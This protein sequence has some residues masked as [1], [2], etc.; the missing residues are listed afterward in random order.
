MA[1]FYKLTAVPSLYLDGERKGEL[2]SVALT[3]QFDSDIRGWWTDNTGHFEDD[4]SEIFPRAV[5]REIVAQ[6]S[7]GKTVEFPGLFEAN[8]IYLKFGIPRAER[9]KAPRGYAVQ[10]AERS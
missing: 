2:R 4:F 5:A 1:G 10:M 7:L 6:L 8:Q 9:R 3:M